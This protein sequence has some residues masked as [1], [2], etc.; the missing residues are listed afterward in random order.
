MLIEMFFH[1]K[2]LQLLNNQHTDN[3]DIIMFM[4]QEQ[5]W[6]DDVINFIFINLIYK[7]I[8]MFYIYYYNWIFLK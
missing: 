1:N 5:Y 7:K 6:Y 2:T 3:L 8:N 4:D